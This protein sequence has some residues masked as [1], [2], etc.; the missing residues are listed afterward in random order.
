M[1]DFKVTMTRSPGRL[2]QQVGMGGIMSELALT[3]DNPE[4]AA[5]LGRCYALLRKWALEARTTETADGDSFAGEA[6]SAAQGGTAYQ[7][8]ATDSVSWATLGIS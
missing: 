4:A 5:A 6:P 7:D 3:L 1:S 2:T 8:R